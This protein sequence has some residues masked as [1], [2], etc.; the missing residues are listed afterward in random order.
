[1]TNVQFKL[2]FDFTA[3]LG[4]HRSVGALHRARLAAAIGERLGRH[5][6]PAPAQAQEPGQG[7]AG[8]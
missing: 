4:S 8:R 7:L 5:G 1:M 3:N 2:I 6:P